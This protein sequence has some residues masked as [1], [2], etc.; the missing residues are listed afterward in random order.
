MHTTTSLLTA[1]A[2]ATLVLASP[3]PA[4]PAI[5]AGPFLG[6]RMVARQAPTTTSTSGLGDGEGDDGGPLIVVDDLTPKELECFDDYMSI[7]GS[8]PTPA[9]ELAEWL[10]TAAPAVAISDVGGITPSLTSM[11]DEV[12]ASVTPPASIAKAFSKY[13][14]E[15]SSWMRAQATNVAS[16]QSACPGKISAI[17][18]LMIM[19][20][21]AACTTAIMGLVQAVNGEATTTVD[22]PQV[23]GGAGN[24]NGNGDDGE[25]DEDKEG[26]GEGEGADDNTVTTTQ[27][28]AGV[29]AARETGLMAAVAAVA[30]GVAGVVAAF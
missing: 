11:C 27:S 18:G 13:E 30:V 1:L 23:T 20:D 15:N 22:G 26:E 21:E 4:A 3:A 24:G 8:H 29:P 6:H 19:S 16:V 17:A 12:F 2:G 9:A 5:T 10:V 14:S 7:V 28:T 25:T